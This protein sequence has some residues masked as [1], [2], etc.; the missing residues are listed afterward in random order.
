MTEQPESFILR[1]LQEIR[2]D[3]AERDERAQAQI[4]SLAQGQLGMRAELRALHDD[5]KDIR[6]DFK[7]LSGKFTQMTSHLHEIAIV[8]D[9]QNGRLDRIERH[10]GLDS[11][12]H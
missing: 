7:E 1:L 6:A 10:L 5:N 3:I 9:H 2:A 12:Q 4:A 11:P 8:L